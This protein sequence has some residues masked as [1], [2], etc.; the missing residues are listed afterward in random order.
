[1]RL[2]FIIQIFLLF[3]LLSAF[4]CVQTEEKDLTINQTNQYTKEDTTRLNLLNDL[5]IKSVEE[6]PNNIECQRANHFLKY[7]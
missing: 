7:A 1:M 6:N 3:V 2:I 4:S 5:A